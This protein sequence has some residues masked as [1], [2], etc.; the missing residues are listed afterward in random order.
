MR[1]GVFGLS[2]HLERLSKDGGQLDVV[3][4]A[5]ISSFSATARIAVSRFLSA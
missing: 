1:Q 3:E 2:T 4:A 5:R